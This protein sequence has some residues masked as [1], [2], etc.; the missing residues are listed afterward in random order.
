MSSGL[1]VGS[2]GTVEKPSQA[3]S[4]LHRKECSDPLATKMCPANHVAT[5]VI[6]WTSDLLPTASSS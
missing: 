6:L 2:W 5:P 4:G 1:P 3:A